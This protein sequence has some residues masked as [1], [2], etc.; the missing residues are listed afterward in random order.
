VKMLIEM[1]VIIKET[2]NTGCLLLLTI[3]MFT[4]LKQKIKEDGRSLCEK[5]LN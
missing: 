3:V 5:V 4:S 1:Y 2:Q